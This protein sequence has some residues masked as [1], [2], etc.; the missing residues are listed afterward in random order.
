VPG[1][2]VT[3]VTGL[4]AGIDLVV[5]DV[6]TTGWLADEAAITEIAAVRLGGGQLTG[7]FSSLVNPGHP[8]PADITQLTG[9]T[10]DMVRRAPPT[11]SVLPAFLEFAREDVLVGHNLRFDLS[12]LNAALE[13]SDRP[14]LA[15]PTVDTLALARR[16]RRG[17]GSPVPST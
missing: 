8:V 14:R 12:F 7:E 2:T 6:E 9:I 10:D 4:L 13:R 5:V 17:V 3:S 11:S 16:L 15:N 1:F